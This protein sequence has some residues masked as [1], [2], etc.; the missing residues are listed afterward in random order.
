MRAYVRACVRACVRTCVRVSVCGW[1]LGKN[2]FP[3]PAKKTS[4]NVFHIILCRPIIMER[5]WSSADPPP[6]PHNE[7]P[8]Q[9]LIKKYNGI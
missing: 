5:D 9:T 1:G 7:R 4:K 8:T 3:I 6:P 2:T